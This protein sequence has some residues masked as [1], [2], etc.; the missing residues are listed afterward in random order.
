[1]ADQ[2]CEDS[3][4]RPNLHRHLRRHFLF[5]ASLATEPQFFDDGERYDGAIVSEQVASL[6]SILLLWNQ[7]NSIHSFPVISKQTTRFS[8]F[9]AR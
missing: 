9:N 1:M 3:Q 5:A 4:I 2:K 7:S 6:T 8:D